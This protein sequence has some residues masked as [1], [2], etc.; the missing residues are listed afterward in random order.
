MSYMQFTSPS[1]KPPTTTSRQMWER[2]HQRLERELRNDASMLPIFSVL[3]VGSLAFSA[4]FMAGG[5][6]S[7]AWFAAAIAVGSGASRW[8]TG[9]LQRRRQ[10]EL[11]YMETVLLPE[12]EAM[13]AALLQHKDEDQW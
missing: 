8:L 5:N 1:Q 7:A 4:A 10:V 2:R 11:E 12:L 9:R 13:E 6:M 3:T